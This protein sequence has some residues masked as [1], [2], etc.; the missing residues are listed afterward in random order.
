MCPPHLVNQIGDLI[1]CQNCGWYI[2]DNKKEL[3][4]TELSWTE[5]K[6]KK[7]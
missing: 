3:K 4:I 7:K 5:Y 2:V 1:V 6:K